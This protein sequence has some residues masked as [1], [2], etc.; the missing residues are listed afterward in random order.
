MP[1]TLAPELL[2]P[3][4]AAEYLGVKVQTLAVWRTTHRYKLPFTK[5]GVKVR[6]RLADLQAWLSSRTH[7][8]TAGDSEQQER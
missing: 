1:A 6:Y 8:G 7:T 5:V 4:Q 2:T 3:E